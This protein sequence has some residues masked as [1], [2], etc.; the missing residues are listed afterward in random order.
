MLKKSS[1]EFSEVT[2][3]WYSLRLTGKD[4]NSCVSRLW[5]SCHPV[6]QLNTRDAAIAACIHA[7]TVQ[8]TVTW[9]EVTAEKIRT[10][11]K[12]SKRGKTTQKT[13]TRQ[14]GKTTQ[15]F[16]FVEGRGMYIY[17][18][19]YYIWW[20]TN[21][22]QKILMGKLPPTSARRW[23]RTPRQGGR[24]ASFAA[25]VLGAAAQGGRGCHGSGA[26]C[27]ESRCFL[28]EIAPRR[29]KTRWE[30]NMIKIYWNMLK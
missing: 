18:Y 24:G 15:K 25:A 14:K 10:R 1:S 11:H 12:K 28:M 5:R 29:S 7:R 20:F 30:L 23:Q 6:L 2:I 3:R 16:C 26:G 4:H 17:I 13:Q 9:E 27:W 19:T 8:L 21:H 22:I